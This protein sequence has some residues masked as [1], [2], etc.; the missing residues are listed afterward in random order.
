LYFKCFVLILAFCSSVLAY[1]QRSPDFEKEVL[2]ACKAEVHDNC[3]EAKGKK[4]SVACLKEK[5]QD[6]NI[7]FTDDCRQKLSAH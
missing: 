4:L 3:K 7:K 6:K 5:S 1:G 2:G